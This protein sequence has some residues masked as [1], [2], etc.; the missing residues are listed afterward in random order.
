MSLAHII[1]LIRL[2]SVAAP[3]SQFPTLDLKLSD[4][5]CFDLLDDQ[6]ERLPEDYEVCSQLITDEE[7]YS[8]GKAAERTLMRMFPVLT[9]FFFVLGRIPGYPDF[10]EWLYEDVSDTMD[11]ESLSFGAGSAGVWNQNISNSQGG[12]VE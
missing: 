2:L 9:V 4:F 10:R 6:R 5:R 3:F 12:W 1:G 7:A 11:H 8:C